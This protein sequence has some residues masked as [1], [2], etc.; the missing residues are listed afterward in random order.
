MSFRSE[1]VRLIVAPTRHA[2]HQWGR[3]EAARDTLMGTGIGA[4]SLAQGSDAVVNAQTRIKPTPPTPVQPS[5]ASSEERLRIDRGSTVE[6]GQLR[7]C[8]QLTQIL[9]ATPILV[10]RG[11]A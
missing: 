2:R 6:T 7:P 5:A 9:N 4:G 10:S 1:P 8:V 11:D 3:L